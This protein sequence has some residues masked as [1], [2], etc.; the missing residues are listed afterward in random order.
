MGCSIR[1]LGREAGR[2][3]IERIE[4]PQAP[5]KDLQLVPQVVLR[6]STAA[7]SSPELS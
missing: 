2:A 1:E 4:N 6:E 5:F 3:L 7:P